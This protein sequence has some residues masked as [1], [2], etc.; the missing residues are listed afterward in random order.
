[1]N[2]PKHI[3]DA[4]AQAAKVFYDYAPDQQIE[5]MKVLQNALTQYQIGQVKQAETQLEELKKA[6]GYAE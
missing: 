2:E 1:M 6:Y 5:Y 4:R 3:A